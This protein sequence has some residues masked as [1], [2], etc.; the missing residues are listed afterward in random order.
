MKK[1][2]T[3][4]VLSSA[5]LSANA[6]SLATASLTFFD[7]NGTVTNN[8]AS[9]A[10]ITSVVYSLGTAGDGIATWDLFGNNGAAGGVA[11]DFLSNGQ[12]F[13]TV[14]FSGLNIAAGSS[15]SFGSLDIDLI[16][17]L[18]PLSVTGGVLDTVGTSLVGALMTIFW[19]NGDTATTNLVQQAWATTQNL[20]F[21][22]APAVSAVPVPAAAWLFA[23]GLAGF[24]GFRRNNQSAA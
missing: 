9:T 6:T 23:T 1:I 7:Q 17:T 15:F 12:H 14:T 4:L 11:S 5:A 3:A 2:I 16:Q 18:T 10:N 21:T 24:A 19:S 22:G 8:A 20:S 13:Q